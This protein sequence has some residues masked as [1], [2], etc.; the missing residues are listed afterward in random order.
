MSATHAAT[1]EEIGELFDRKFASNFEKVNS[2]IY[3]LQ[4]AHLNHFNLTLDIQRRVVTL[5]DSVIDIQESLDF[6]TMAEEKDAEATINH[7]VRI[8]NLESLSNLDSISPKH[9][10]ELD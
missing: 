3:S 5:E 2:S 7:E 9:L 10:S 1:I 8:S 6:L 4:E